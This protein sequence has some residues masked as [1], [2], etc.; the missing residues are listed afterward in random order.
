[1]TIQTK[2]SSILSCVACSQEL[3][4]SNKGYPVT[5]PVPIRSIKEHKAGWA[6][7]SRIA[8]S[9]AKAV[10]S[11]ISKPIEIEQFEDSIAPNIDGMCA[12]FE[13]KAVVFVNK[14][15]NFCWSRFYVAKEMAHL[16][17]NHATT[18]LRTTDTVIISHTINALLN[19]LKVEGDSEFIQSE[20]DAYMG[21]VEML[22]PKPAVEEFLRTQAS[23]EQI[24][25]SMKVPKRISSTR[26]D[27]RVVAM[28]NE[29][30]SS[31]MYDVAILRERSIRAHS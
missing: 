1:M 3:S 2:I 31:P 27:D 9:L 26:I 30:Y 10:E 12:E 18:E 8:Y 24:A 7:D 4:Q 28:H 23:Y 19:D 21:A 13:D 25:E 16:L 11:I 5:K 29:I 22:L 15:H 20:L 17:M 6:Q 14:K